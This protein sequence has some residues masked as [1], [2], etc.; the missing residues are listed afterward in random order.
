M[1]ASGA[2]PARGWSTRS[3]GEFGRADLAES[4]A[5]RSSAARKIRRSCAALRSEQVARMEAP[6]PVLLHPRSTRSDGENQPAHL[7][8][9]P[10]VPISAPL[11]NPP[12]L[13]NKRRSCPTHPKV[14]VSYPQAP[15]IPP[16]P[17]QC[18]TNTSVPD[19]PAQPL[20]HTLYI[21][22]SGCHSSPGVC[23][24]PARAKVKVSQFAG[25]VPFE[26]SKIAGRVPH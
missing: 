23:R 19:L 4:R 25:R 8:E 21:S 2:V 12:K 11:K 18:L 3:A 24:W 5:A 14:R 22:K 13:T 10:P 6:G 16:S 17:L 7:A 15:Y 20:L 1:G 26:R 9:S